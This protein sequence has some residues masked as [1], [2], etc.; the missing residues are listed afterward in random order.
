M[1][2]LNDQYIIIGSLGTSQLLSILTG[3]TVLF[4]VI[5][6]LTK[7]VSKGFFLILSVIFLL[8]CEAIMLLVGFSPNYQYTTYVSDN[9][10]HTIVVE[11]K[12]TNTEIAIRFYKKISA[13]IYTPVHNA[14]FT[15]GKRDKYNLGDYT[16]SFDDEY[17]K[18]TV[19]LA[20][21]AAF[22]VPHK[23]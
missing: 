22:W 9:K 11:E 16:V 15:D 1:F 6:I 7:R 5:Y 4:L 19:P 12:S 14:T 21:E 8:S 18:I 3:L 10:A 23:K 20:S 13:A 2:Y 17:T